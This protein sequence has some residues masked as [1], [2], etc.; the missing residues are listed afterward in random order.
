MSKFP[1]C[2]TLYNQPTASC[3][4]LFIVET[5][6]KTENGVLYPTKPSEND[7]SATITFIEFESR[8][9]GIT[10]WHV[11]SSYRSL[12]K[13]HS[14]DISHSM[15]LM[16]N[17]Q[18]TVIDRFV[19]PQPPLAEPVLDIALREFNPDLLKA[20]GKTPIKLDIAKKIPN[21]LNHAYAVGFPE[22][23]KRK[24]NTNTGHRIGMQS[25]EVLAEIN[26]RPR[27]RFS[28]HSELSD[29]PQ[30]TGLSG[31]S[32]GPIFWTTKN[33]YGLLGI[34]Y[35]GCINSKLTNQYSVNI[36]GEFADF[37]KLYDWINQAT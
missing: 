4:P 31:M 14:S 26:T 19:R 3:A 1:V 7:R 23:E 11:I 15:Y 16:T 18:N 22:K 28:L 13:A 35:E 5:F 24:I 12:L 8:V 17:G 34:I 36:F 21:T 29:P 30:T 9:F 32:G 6:E 20:I 10:C 27:S 33:D 37:H 25:V 2:D